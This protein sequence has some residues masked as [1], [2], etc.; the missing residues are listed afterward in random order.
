MEG[1][2]AAGLQIELE[3]EDEDEKALAEMTEDEIQILN[4]QFAH[5]YAS[6]PELRA[7]LKDEVE[8]LTLLQKY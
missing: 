5:I 2:G 7:A 6:D 3:D 8:Q 1:G 4:S